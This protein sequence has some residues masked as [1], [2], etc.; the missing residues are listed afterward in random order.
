[1]IN[2]K[3]R[4]LIA[5]DHKV[6]LDG[7]VALLQAEE[8]FSIE[9]TAYDGRRALELIRNGE[10]DV[11]MLDINMPELDGIETARSIKAERPECKIIILTTHRENEIIMRLLEIG[12][13]GYLLKNST[14][15]ELVSAIKKVAGG[16]RYFCDEVLAS[17]LHSHT[18]TEKSPAKAAAPAIALTP[19]EN[20]ILELLSKEYTNEK[21]AATLHISYRTVETHRKNMMQKIGAGNLA[22]L[23]RYAYG[24]GLL[25]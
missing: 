4:L 11:C 15:Q 7:L 1:M 13:M 25:K 9:A 20:E 18:L 23:L 6:M 8:D 5:D 3:I 24:N 19:R 21:V 2:D 10:Y 17:I 22:G 12:V 14:R 16:G